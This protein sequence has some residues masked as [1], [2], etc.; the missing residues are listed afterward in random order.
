[1]TTA[2]AASVRK[3]HVSLNVRDLDHSVVFYRVLFNRAP[4]RYYPDYAKF[5]L[6]D[7]PLVLSLN[8]SATVGGGALNHA[9]LRVASSEE[10]VEIQRR[11]EEAGFTTIRE[12]G[13]ACCYALQTKFWIPDPD[14]TMWEVY[15]L[16]EDID[17]HGD[18]SVPRADA[19]INGIVQEKAAWEHR[20]PAPVPQVIPHDANSLDQ[21]R[22]EGAINLSLAEGVLDRLLGEAF[23]AL[24]PGGSLQVHGLAGDRP[25]GGPLPPLPGPASAVERIPSFSESVE[26]MLKA[27]F[28]G[29]RFQTFS[30]QHFVHQ[31]VPLREVLLV[32]DKP[33]ART[34]KA[35]Q[36]AIYLGPLAQVMDDFGNLFMRGKAVALNMHDWQ[37]LKN[38]VAAAQFHFVE[39][40]ALSVLP[41]GCCAS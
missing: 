25:I 6:E 14:Q 26:A 28:T 8:P 41:G 27:G 29:V 39:N 9:G 36:V 24:R 34:N 40:N 7:P 35:T 30:R 2:S 37:T 22:L 3:F 10:L 5:E 21:V 19:F 38:S 17:H 23:Q 18:G 12:D 15:T 1:M 16:H 33:G 4:A 32:G 13:V 20:I 31:G 11:V